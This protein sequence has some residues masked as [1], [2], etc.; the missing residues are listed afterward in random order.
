MPANGIDLR[1]KSELLTF[2]EIK[3]LAEMMV[4]FGV[5]KIRVTGGEPLVRNGVEELCGSLS[6]IPNL[7]PLALS[8]NGIALAEKAEA[9]FGSGVQHLNVSLDTLRADRF[10][11]ITRRTGLEKVLQGI[12]RSISVG[13]A[14]IKINSVVIKGFNDDEILDFVRFA[15]D[16][17]LNVRFIEFMPFADNEWSSDFLVPSD[18]IKQSIE[19]QYTIFPSNKDSGIQGPSEEYEIA[20]TNAKVGFISTISHPFC[21]G[22]NRLRLSADGRLRVCLFA[23]ASC[24]LR[25]PLR[26]GA[27]PKDIAMLINDALAGK[28]KE[29]PRAEELSARV[30][31]AMVSVGG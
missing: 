2:D 30:H 3:T 22:C 11:Y 13:F 10:S 24:D 27:S 14:S 1:P 9:L 31:H 29:H 4:G 21:S 12:E 20:G 5:R 23:Q 18:E 8:T 15:I 7:E 26:A 28:W 17:S 19:S 25:T 16:R 6:R